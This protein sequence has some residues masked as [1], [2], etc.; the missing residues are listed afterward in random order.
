[1]GEVGR[2]TWNVGRGTWEIGSGWLGSSKYSLR[3]TRH[4][5][6]SASEMHEIPSDLASCPHVICTLQNVAK[7]ALSLDLHNLTACVGAHHAGGNLE[8]LTSIQIDITP[9]RHPRYDTNL[10]LFSQ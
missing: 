2:E 3:G 7:N 1:M 10:A 4:Y 9:S 8:L 6:V 5:A